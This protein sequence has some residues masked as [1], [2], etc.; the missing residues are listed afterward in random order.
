MTL[1]RL[2]WFRRRPKAVE[3]HSRWVAAL[4]AT[5]AWLLRLSFIAQIGLCVIAAY[6]LFYTVIPLYQK[7]MIDEQIAQ[8]TLELEK[9]RVDLSATYG[10]AR[11][12]AVQNA[13][14]HLGV[15]CLGLN[16]ASALTNPTP[17]PDYWVE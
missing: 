16:R 12:L 13:I 5:D 9:A 11:A 6:G 4:T 7:A 17:Q 10:R 1:S 15:Q 2:R 3:R 8:K 14:F